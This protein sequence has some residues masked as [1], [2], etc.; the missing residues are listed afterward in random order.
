MLEAIG[1]LVGGL[2]GA[3]QKKIGIQ[4]AKDALE[5]VMRMY[6]GISVPEAQKLVVEELKSQGEYT[7]E[8]EDAII[9]HGTEIEKVKGSQEL[10]NSQMSALQQMQQIA[11]GGLRLEDRAAL[12]EA[13]NQTERDAQ[14]KQAQ[15]L[16]GMQSRGLGGSGA[17]LASQLAAAQ[18]GAELNSNQSMNVAAE[19]NKRALQAMMNQANL[20]GQMENTQYNQDT[21]A[22][23]A[24][25]QLNRFNTQ[26]MQGI[27]S[28]N[29]NNRNQAQAVN[30]GEKQRIADA[31]V[32]NRRNEDLRY[33]QALQQKFQ[34]EMSKTGAIAGARTGIGAQDQAQHNN[35]AQKWAGL[36]SSVGKIGD[37][38]AMAAMTGGASS[39]IPQQSGASQGGNIF[40]VSNGS[41]LSADLGRPSTKKT[42]SSW[43]SSLFGGN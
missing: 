14:A 17:E 40:G 13:R 10:K 16:Q 2:V 42:N 34:N 23:T 18:S 9:Q 11:K 3:N 33:Q 5:D 26:T 43:L 31:N 12:N 24:K 25:D 41:D 32:A 21:T 35:S 4:K 1:G 29:L 8:M 27:N 7:P 19:A 39:A 20:A 30:L 36:A 38:A 37:E 22:A 28:K 6:Q 15:I